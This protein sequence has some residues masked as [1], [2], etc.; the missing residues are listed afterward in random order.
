MNDIANLC[1]RVGA[2]V[3]NVRKGI[4]TDTRIGSKFLYAG[5]GYGGYCSPKDVKALMHTGIDNDYHIEVIEAVERVNEKQK[6]IVYDRAKSESILILLLWR[7]A[8]FVLAIPSYFVKNIYDAADGTDVIALM[9]EWHQFRMPSW[10]VIRK[11]LTG[12]VIIDGR[13]INDRQELE[14][15]FFV[16]TR[17]GEK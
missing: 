2:H 7:N 10:N 17:I 5:C 13:N 3:D 11:V 4:G 1:E 14:E 8:N 6:S 12:N 16:Y 9:T 15:Q